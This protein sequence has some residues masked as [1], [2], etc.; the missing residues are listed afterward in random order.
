M[1]IFLLS[2]DLFSSFSC[3]LASEGLASTAVFGKPKHSLSQCCLDFD[4]SEGRAWAGLFCLLFSKFLD[5][6]K[7]KSLAVFHPNTTAGREGREGEAAW[8]HAR[9]NADDVRELSWGKYLFLKRRKGGNQR[10]L[11]GFLLLSLRQEGLLQ[12]PTMQI[13]LTA[14]G[15][16]ITLSSCK[17]SLRLT[18]VHCLELP[19]RAASLGQ[20]SVPGDAV[21]WCA[22]S[23]SLETHFGW[24]LPCD[25]GAHP[26]SS[27]V[28]TVITANTELPESLVPLRCGGR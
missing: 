6:K 19:R 7:K 1:G 8:L 11:R 17:A 10:A 28:F 24:Q 21:E 25:T 3:P 15:V 18:Q 14:E 2:F 9:K 22:L 26:D 4:S 12:L 27:S 5:K 13:L 16:C 23:R 20:F